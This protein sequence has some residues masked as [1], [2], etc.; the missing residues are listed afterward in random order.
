MAD[1]WEAQTPPRLAGYESWLYQMPRI[2]SGG[3]LFI[4]MPL[5]AHSDR[6]GESSTRWLVALGDFG[7]LGDAG[8]HLKDIIEEEICR[9]AGTLTD[10]ASILETLNNDLHFADNYACLLV[11]VFDGDRHEMTLANA[12][13]LSPLLRRLDRQTDLIGKEHAGMPLWII[14]SQNYQNVTV[15]FGPGEIVIFYSDGITDLMDNQHNLFRL[16]RLRQA[17]AKAPVGAA[18]V[19]QS[20][21]EAVHQFGQGQTQ[22]DDITLLCLGRRS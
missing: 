7:G 11:A 14:P 12:G 3:D 6:S 21:F 10:P 9:L 2:G 20:I 8:P 17:I 15:P 1:Q 5:P 16:D 13:H 19:G 22:Y 18:T 4:S